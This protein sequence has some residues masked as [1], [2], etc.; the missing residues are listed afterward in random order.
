M[1]ILTV[2]FSQA[3][4]FIKALFILIAQI[5]LQIF[6]LSSELNAE[7]H[8]SQSEGSHSRE[9]ESS[10]WILGMQTGLFL[11]LGIC[12]NWGQFGLMIEHTV[13]VW[14]W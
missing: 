7:S 5:F 13:S 10:N 2:I 6:P 8:S 1:H 4:I 12:F 3:N 9:V 11:L 14:N